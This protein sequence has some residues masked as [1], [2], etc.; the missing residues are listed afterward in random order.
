MLENKVKEWVRRH[1]TQ[2]HECSLPEL[3]RL[4]DKS[5]WLSY[6]FLV[7]SLILIYLI[8]DLFYNRNMVSITFNTLLVMCLIALYD[9][10]RNR[11]SLQLF[12]YLKRRNMDFDIILKLDKIMKKLGIEEE[13]QNADVDIK[14]D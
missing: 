13:E 10:Q 7:G 1:K 3:E 11:H 2:R 12:I 9:E 5:K 6:G 8:A 4:A 14:P